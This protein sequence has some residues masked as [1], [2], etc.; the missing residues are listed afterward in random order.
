MN[1]CIIK[2]RRKASKNNRAERKGM[3]KCKNRIK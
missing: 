2:E 3:E 1:V